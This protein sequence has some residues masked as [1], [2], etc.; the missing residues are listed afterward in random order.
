MF[1]LAK[2]LF[3]VSQKSAKFL[4]KVVKKLY[5]NL[6][7]H[8][9]C[10]ARAAAARARQRQAQACDCPM[11]AGGARV[12]HAAECSQGFRSHTLAARAKSSS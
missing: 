1:E 9:M 4:E 3:R 2:F 8:A 12:A 6:N 11:M 5:P 10:D 7:N